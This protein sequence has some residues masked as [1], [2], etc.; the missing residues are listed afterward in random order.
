M[1]LTWFGGTTMR[2]HI[3]GKMLVIDGAG[4]PEGV[5]PAELLSGADSV[6]ALDDGGLGQVAANW[7][8]RRVGAL[9]DAG[10]D[11]EVQMHRIGAGA[12]V[13][14]AIGEQ[15]LLLVTGAVEPIG[16]WTGNAVVVVM[17]APETLPELAA[18]VL[19]RLRPKLIAV[20]GP[21][22]AAE[23]VIALIGTSLDGTGLV[24]LEPG[25]A[26]EV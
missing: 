16:R 15:P 5:E 6:V 1:K 21:E 19:E 20:A 3:G 12:I 9:L 25:L 23:Q 4:A 2:V 18:T 8:P 14:D 22:A 10:D 17:G 24:S 11:T 7:M 26:L 13:V